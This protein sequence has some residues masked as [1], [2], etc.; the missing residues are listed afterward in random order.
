VTAVVSDERDSVNDCMELLRGVPTSG[1]LRPSTWRMPM[2]EFGHGTHVGLRRT[3]NEDTYYADATLGLFLVA[4]GMGGHQHGEVAAALARDTIVDSVRKGMS[5]AEAVHRAAGRLLEHAQ[6]HDNALP[7]GTTV[8][9]IRCSEQ[10]YEVAWVG[11]SRIYQWK[12]SLRQ[13]S[14]DHSLVQRLVEAGA[15]D[16]AQAKRHPQRNILTQALGITALEQLH[17]SM[18]SGRLEPGMSFLVCSDGLTEELNDAGIEEIVGRC[19][20]AAQECLDHL[21]LAALESGGS[22]NITAILARIH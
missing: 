14:H 21:L 2:I 4:D 5:L 18:A 6:H 20:L 19:D 12:N 10:D 16:E 22:D 9:A 1:M 11:D 17:I 3:R 8:A 13:I 15:I 7:M